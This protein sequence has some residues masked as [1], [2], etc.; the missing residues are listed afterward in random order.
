MGFVAAVAVLSAMLGPGQSI[1]RAEPPLIR[2]VQSGRWSDAATWQGGKVPGSGARVQV[3]T[4]HVVTYDIKTEGAVRSVH[5]A[6]LLRFDP[7]RDT[8]LDVGLIKIQAGDDA[9]ESGFDCENHVTAPDAKR[10]RAAL[11][12]GLAEQPIARDHSAVIRLTMVTGLDPDECPAIVCCG[13]RWDVHGS[14]LRRTWVK[15]AKPAAARATTLALIEPV[16]DWR[17]GDRVI[18][19][20]TGRKPARQEAEI[21]SVLEHPQTEER[22]IRAIKN[23]GVEVVLDA[24]LTFT[25]SSFENRRGEVA[26]LSRNVIIESAAPGAVRGHTMYHR[27]SAGSISYAEFRHLGKQG[28]LGKYSLHFHRAG[29]TMRG[30]SVIGASVWDSA[31]RWITIH[32]T[33]TL[34][35]RDCVGYKSTGHGFF[36]EDGTE[37]ENILDRNLAVQACQGKPLP[38]QVFPRDGNQGAGF[39]WADSRNAFTR[40]VAVECDGYGYRF[41]A[42]EEAGAGLAVSVKDPDGQRRKVDI[43]AL[44]FIRF[45]GNE[46]HSQP[47]YGL[48]LGGGAGS[49]SEG[50]VG[51]VGPDH[52]HPFMI[53]NF[54]VW[55]TRWGVTLAAPSVLIDGLALAECEYGFWRPHYAGHAYRGVKGNRVGF[56]EAFAVG[57]RPNVTAY[58]SPLAPVD[59]RPPV[60]VMTRIGPVRRGRLVV[61]GV[62]VDDGVVRSVRVNGEAA[63]PLAPNY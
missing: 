38:G 1:A 26:N 57:K 6:G 48:N 22:I 8:R 17:V 15:L 9:G 33:N 31:N 59:D 25:H 44:P 53:R 5:V 4:G 37:V 30:T 35:V 11:E 43:R 56:P 7:E 52:R 60:T 63:Q 40:N 46:A 18:V 34:V 20:A 54:N 12:V 10:A 27:Y 24:P 32:G 3:R 14:P 39:W 2:S 29:D 28:K 50:G 41:D 58:P 42:P 23:D 13:G 21:V 49:E 36:L 19:T 62:T 47:R 45:E 51:E 55:D 16:A 61:E